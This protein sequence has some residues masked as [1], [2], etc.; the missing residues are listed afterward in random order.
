MKYTYA[1][2]V[3]GVREQSKARYATIEEATAAMRYLK[4]RGWSA[5]VEKE[6]GTFVPVVG[7]QKKPASK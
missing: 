1:Y 7:A 2:L 5:W 6:D 3:H 4:R